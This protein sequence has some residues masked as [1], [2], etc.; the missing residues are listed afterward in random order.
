A[1]AGDGCRRP[2]WH[3]ILIRDHD[4]NQKIVN[5]HGK[6]HPGYGCVDAAG[7]RSP[8]QPGPRTTRPGVAPVCSPSRSTCTPLTKTWSTP[9][10]YCCGA[11]WV[12]WSAKIGRAHV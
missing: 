1:W 8:R 10:A 3:S 4:P 2:P 6:F 12:A 11:A 5:T 7:A 9:V